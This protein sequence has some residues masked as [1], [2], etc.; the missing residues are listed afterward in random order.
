M[1]DTGLVVLVAGL[2]LGGLFV[3]AFISDRKADQGGARFVS[4]PLVY[5]LSLA[6]YCTSW[7][8]YGAVGSAA[9]SGLE[10]LTIYSGP[11]M[12]FIGWWFL[13]RKLARVCKTQRITSIADFISARF[14]KSAL[15]SALVT[16][17]AV[18][19]TTPYIALQLKAVATSFDALTTGGTILPDSPPG[20][21]PLL[22][23]TAFWAAILMVTFVILF[24]T[25]NLGADERH[26]GVVAAIAF[27]SLV[28]LLALV[29]IGLFA[30]FYVHD[31]PASL[32][33]AATWNPAVERLMGL[34]D[35]ITG[36]WVAMTVLAAAAVV[37]L[38]RQFQV[39]IVENADERHLAAASWAFP[40][41][42][43]VICLF[44]VPI[45][46]GGLI[47]QPETANPDLFVLTVP[48]AAGREELAVLAFI[49]GLSAATSMVIVASI[50]LSI[51]VSNHL[52]MPLLL[53]LPAARGRGRSDLAGALLSSRRLSIGVI[54]GLGFLYY[55]AAG[56]SNALASIGLISFAGAAQ[57]L[58]ALMAAVYWRRA[59]GMGAT[60]GLVAGSVVWAWTMLVPSFADAGWAFETLVSHGPWDIDFLR[61]T[62]LFGTGD[63]DDLAHAVF[64]SL[65]TNVAALTLGSLASRPSAMESLQ[66]AMFVDVFQRTDRRFEPALP[67]SAT[68]EDLYRVTRNILGEERA[69]A[70][71]R[72]EAARQGKNGHL[73]M[74]DAR[75]ITDVE[76]ELAGSIGAASARHMV[77]RIATGE[78]LSVD[79]VIAILNETKQAI[80]HSRELEQKSRELER[81]AAELRRAN[82]QLTAL[83]RRKDDFLSQVSHEL[84]TPM[85]SIRSFAEILVSD[86]NISLERRTRFLSIIEHESKRLT[87]LL[88]EILDL[89]RM[90][91]GDI[92]WA[93]TATDLA[94]T[95]HEAAAAMGGLAESHRARISVDLGPGPLV[96]HGD[97]D[98]LKQVFINLLS[99]AIK[100]NDGPAPEVSVR[101]GR[102]IQA[103]T[104]MVCISV[105][106][107]GP[108]IA[109]GDQDT[110][111]TKFS[112]GW[113][114]RAGKAKG[115]GLGLAI[116]RQIAR[117]CG[118]DLVLAKS[119]SR[120]STFEVRLP[121]G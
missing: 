9:R 58:P 39:A 46:I 121:I 82:E 65:S 19:S 104:T 59:T 38:P 43:L 106:D 8:F 114:D 22:A 87:R 76:R 16:L 56:S 60:L 13:L 35:G 63:W 49:G 28:K 88:D 64:W 11:T 26:P 23:D 90:E 45:A 116:S 83:D 108:G 3:L 15:L 10:F 101:R 71:F 79:A 92:D 69:Y 44:V 42:L 25:R 97:P 61:P 24:G 72:D 117:A 112:R 115:A 77:S 73:P 94:A 33:N 41:Y 54:L 74:A 27:E 62:A 118:G 113:E 36:R 21:R 102:V 95:I 100:F 120:G 6:V 32:F 110:L 103:E 86:P 93:I 75:F 12:V 67:R 98:R 105:R 85:T 53:R 52:V 1:V 111:F 107:N 57:F 47:T 50:A 119:D 81:T 29:T 66:S 2:Y 4:S 51:M 109:A 40:L 78:R 48:L 80:L 55:R 20:S 84:R 96:V 31:G 99:N 91:Q 17:I 37:C 70:I 89:G 7:T 34:P 5:T 68:A 14:G 18:V 30:L